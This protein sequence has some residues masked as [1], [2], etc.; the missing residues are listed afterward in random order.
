MQESLT[1]AAR[2]GSG[3][4]AVEIAYADRSLELSVT[5]P[6]PPTANGGPEVGGHGLQGMRERAALLGGTLSV[7]RHVVASACTRACPT[8][9]PASSR[10]DP[11]PTPEHPSPEHPGPIMLVDDDPLMRAGLRTVISSDPASEVVGEASDGRAAI[12]S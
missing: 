6:R 3:P 2:H 8:R 7:D 11:H 9:L 4:A 5:N 10:D 1:N 12:S